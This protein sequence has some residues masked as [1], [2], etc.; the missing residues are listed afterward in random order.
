MLRLYPLLLCSFAL[1]LA[2]VAQQTPRVLFDATRAEMANNADWVLDADTRNLRVGSD[3]TMI[4]G[5]SESNPQ[6]FSTPAQSGITASTPETYWSGAL[7]SW[8]VALAKRGFLVETLPNDSRLTYGDATNAQDLSNYQVYVVDEPNIRFTT[9]EKAALLTYVRNGGGL[10]MIADH[11]VSDRN[12]DGWDSPKIW[13]DLL[14][15]APG[16]NPFGFTFDLNNLVVNTTNVPTLP[17]DS[18]LHGPAGD[19]GA[20]EYHNGATL[21]LLPAAN[22]S[23]RGIIYRPGVSATGTTGAF[24]AY[25]R[26]GQGKV[27]ALGDSSPPD[28]GTG[29]P[30]DNLYNGWSAEANGDHARVLLNATL[31]LAARRGMPLA[32]RS[33]QSFALGIY[34]NPASQ[35]VQLTC[36]V[37]PAQVSWYNLLGQPLSVPGNGLGNRTITYTL[38]NLP[39]GV[40]VVRVLLP[41]GRLA[42]RRVIRR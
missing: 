29:D 39:A 2:A 15:S 4:P 40:Y 17:A 8:G 18:L 35:Q 20:M 11:D 25:A 36:E 10:F 38:E 1:P 27:V 34:P 30:G 32:A 5:G 22:N 24:M 31:W 26:Y 13:N 33:N 3:G 14:N 19:V 16:G 9:A 37:P 28:D 6:R 42:S 12:G 21:T 41:D 23:V 7:S